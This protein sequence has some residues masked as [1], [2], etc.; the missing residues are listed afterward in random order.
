[1][2]AFCLCLLTACGGHLAS[3]PVDAAADVNAPETTP[4]EPGCAVGC[5]TTLA[6]G[7]K[8]SQLAVDSQAVF[9]VEVGVRVASVPLGGGPIKTLDVSPSGQAIALDE[10]NVYWVT[11]SGLTAIAK[12]GTNE[13][14]LEMDGNP[15]QDSD[16]IAVRSGKVYWAVSLPSGAIKTVDS[17]GGVPFW[18]V[19]AQQSPDRIVVDATNIY[20]TALDG[21]WRS[22]LAGGDIVHIA[23]DPAVGLAL[24]DTRVYWTTT[25]SVHAANHDGS[26]PWTFNQSY[27][28]PA[29]IAVDDA[30]VYWSTKEPVIERVPKSGGTP[31]KL[32]GAHAT[33]MVVT[34]T[35][36]YWADADQHAIMKLVLK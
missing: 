11:K 36:L 30:Y 4:V 21:V 15:T 2:R 33:D 1:M 29:A 23:S 20:W 8:P 19:G 3:D 5:I 27:Y 24:D 6:S 12:S 18:A 22:D 26:E 28:S 32:V 17:A 9:F 10:S 16:G 25:T 35:S 13:H 7:V 34:A 14:K 31:T